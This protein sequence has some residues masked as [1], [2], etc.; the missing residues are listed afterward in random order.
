M[1]KHDKSVFETI[2]ILLASGM[3]T[4][5]YDNSDRK[6]KKAVRN[7]GQKELLKK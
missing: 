3:V 5:E 6:V 2:E 4:T 7:S 1:T